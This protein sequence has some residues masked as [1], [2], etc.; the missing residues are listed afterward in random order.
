M[1]TRVAN[2]VEWCCWKWMLFW[3]S[4]KTLEESRMRWRT[5]DFITNGAQV[6]FIVRVELFLPIF[7][8]FLSKSNLVLC[9]HV[10]LFPAVRWPPFGASLYNQQ[11]LQTFSSTSCW[12]VS[13]LLCWRMLYTVEGLRVRRVGS[14]KAKAAGGVGTRSPSSESFSDVWLD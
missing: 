11:E 10:W 2:E 4:W 8:I 1:D 7:I 3:Q 12:W 13:A 5:R 6:G 14:D 9:V